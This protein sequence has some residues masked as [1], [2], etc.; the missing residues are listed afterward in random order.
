[1]E[2]VPGDIQ[3]LK[4]SVILHARTEYEDFPEPERKRH[5]LRLWLTAHGGFSDGDAFLQQG[6]PR[7]PGIDSDTG[8][9]EPRA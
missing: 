6:I 2:F 5:L 4:N 1:M 9:T 3:L 8:S 7:K